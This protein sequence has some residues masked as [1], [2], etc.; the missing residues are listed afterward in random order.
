L[1]ARQGRWPLHQP[2]LHRGWHH[3]HRPLGDSTVRSDPYVAPGR[4][5]LGD[6]TVVTETLLNC[7]CDACDR[8]LGVTTIAAVT[9]G[10]HVQV[11]ND[12]TCYTYNPLG[13]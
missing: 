10:S 9:D 7:Q 1:L 4:P 13:R 8:L 2:G 6:A 11:T 3:N 5:E 12:S